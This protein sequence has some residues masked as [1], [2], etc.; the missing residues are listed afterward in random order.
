MS[1][2]VDMS[3]DFNQ[4]LDELATVLNEY[5]TTSSTN[6]DKVHN[7][8]NKSAEL[9]ESVGSLKEKIKKQEKVIKD[10]EILINQPH[11]DS[12]INKCSKKPLEYLKILK[13]HLKSKTMLNN[14]D[15][16][17]IDEVSNY[18][19]SIFE[20]SLGVLSDS[21]R[22][23]IK[24]DY[25]EGINSQGGYFVLPQYVSDKVSRFFETSP[26]DDLC[27][28]IPCDSDIQRWYIDD[29]LSAAG[30]W[31]GETEERTVTDTARIGELDITMH[32]IYAEPRITIRLVEDANFDIVSWLQQKS[33]QTISLI[34]TAA[35]INGDGSKKPRGILNY[36]KWG[37]QAVVFGNDANYEREKLEYIKSGANGLFTYD[38]LVN[39]Q[40]SLLSPYQDNAVFATT[41]QGWADILQLKDSQNRPLI[42][43]QNLLK[44]GASEILLG[45]PVRIFAPS[46][47]STNPQVDAGLPVPATGAAAMIYGDF[48]EGYCIA[49]RTGYYTITDM[50]TE[51]QWI[52]YY[53]RTRLGGAVTSY[54]ALKVH[55]LSE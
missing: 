35:F 1:A 11:N 32:E 38:G 42:Q 3:K 13:K 2:D 54:Q 33:T 43:L 7:L 18:T 9:I 44:S 23:Y 17:L 36:G 8:A 41:R 19:F 28:K 49:E 27:R 24:K 31:V 5:Q 37:N 6:K 40:L 15:R 45:K 50:I 53:V 55:E 21:E 14:I 48:K 16:A 12:K 51:K 47:A 22:Q 39:L 26:M 4:K 20:K 46:N 52:K 10:L 29:N 25:L 30:G 34:R